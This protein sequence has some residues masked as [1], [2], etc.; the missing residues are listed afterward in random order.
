MWKMEIKAFV[1]V[2]LFVKILGKRN[3]LSIS[4]FLLN[5]SDKA[6]KWNYDRKKIWAEADYLI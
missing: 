1:T 5:I 4:G 6:I 3:D 2:W